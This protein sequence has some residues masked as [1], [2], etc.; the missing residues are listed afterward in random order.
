MTFYKTKL[1]NMK[2]FW[3]IFLLFLTHFIFAQTNQKETNSDLQYIPNEYV[4]QLEPTADAS[5]F[6][7]KIKKEFNESGIIFQKEKSLFKDLNVFLLK[8]KT[9]VKD[10]NRLLR[11]LDYFSEVKRVGQNFQIQQREKIPNDPLFINQWD[12]EIIH[13]PEVWE[14]TTGGVTAL[15][16]TIV[17]AMME[18]GDWQHDDLIGNVWINWGEVNNDGIDNDGNGYVDDFFGWNVVDSSDVIGFWGGTHGT[19]VG[20]IIGAK[21]DNN[22]GLSGVN[23]NVK[24]MWVHNDLTISKIIESYQ[25]V[26]QNRKLYNDTNGEKGAF[27]VTTN[28]SFGIDGDSSTYPDGLQLEDNP[29]FPMWCD[30]HEM[31]GGVGILNV[32]ATA[33]KSIDV[34]VIG[35]MPSICPTDHLIVVAE[36]DK[37]DKLSS[38]YGKINVDLTAPGDGSPTTTLN[39]LYETIGSTSGA[40]PHVSGGIALLYSLPCEKLAR[41]ARENPAA[42]SLRMKKFILDGVDKIAEQSNKTVSGGRLNLEKSM[43]L[44]FGYCGTETGILKINRLSPNPAESYIDVAFTPNEF[45]KYTIRIYNTIG[46]LMYDDEYIA[47]DFLPASFRLEGMDRFRTG[48]YFLTISNNLDFTTE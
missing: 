4:I 45:G 27:V 34:D 31:L 20:G 39:N 14:V 13:A 25:Y 7:Q 30:M 8:S 36:N 29:L 22:I 44:I 2:T 23:W 46:Q 47:E 48:L 17:V 9:E 41:E 10:V 15:G 19:R 33:N 5:V 26:Y 3:T 16:D 43:Q 24:I 12:M 37:M 1:I 21:G 32:G 11:R 35:D 38:G 28:A 40:T 18:S 6:F 42:T